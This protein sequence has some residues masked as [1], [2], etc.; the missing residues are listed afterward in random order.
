MVNM[1]EEIKQTS[2]KLPAKKHKLLKIVAEAMDKSLNE[3][4]I[5]MVDDFLAKNKKYL[6]ELY[7]EIE[8]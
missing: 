5:E 3:I 7:E 8:E 6:R 2:I 4:Y 1:A